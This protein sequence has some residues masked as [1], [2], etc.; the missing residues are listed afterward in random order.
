MERLEIMPYIHD[1]VISKLLI[2]LEGVTTS[3]KFL[4]NLLPEFEILTQIMGINNLS[5]ISRL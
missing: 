3:T 5:K 4:G 2:V 1:H